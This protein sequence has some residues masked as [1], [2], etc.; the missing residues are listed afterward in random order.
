MELKHDLSG[1]FFAVPRPSRKIE[2]GS[3]PAS[4]GED[5]SISAF[6]L[7]WAVHYSPHLVGTVWGIQLLPTNVSRVRQRAI[8]KARQ[9]TLSY[10][11]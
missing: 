2:Q 3:G 10:S 8:A 11:P 5:L 9:R 4:P 7:F 1:S 6:E